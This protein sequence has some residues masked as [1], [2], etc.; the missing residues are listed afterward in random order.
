V[1]AQPWLAGDLSA[2]ALEWASANLVRRHLDEVT[3]QRNAMVGKTLSAV[4]E[5]LTKEINHWAKRANA[6]TIEAKA[7][8][9]PSMQPENALRKKDEL[10]ARLVARTKELEAQRELAS[11][12]PTVAGCALILPQGLLDQAS[13][14]GLSPMADQAAR[15]EVERIAMEA[16]T[17]AERA[18]GYTVKDVSKEK[19]GWDLTSTPPPPGLSRHIEVKGR[20]ALAETFTVTANEVLEALNQGDKF[21]LAI[22]TVDGERVEEPV[23]IRSPFTKELEAVSAN[24]SL[25]QYLARGKKAG[26]V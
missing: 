3:A 5:R 25:A 7:G 14:K 17:R 9:Q 12:P 19:C 1:L 16:V 22:V 6:L 8:R 23:Y 24:Y 20:H 15:A 13:G 10:K 26:E 11:N 4:H 21:L 2:R 18:L